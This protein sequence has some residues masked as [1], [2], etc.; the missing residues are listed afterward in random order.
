MERFQLF[1][2]KALKSYEVADHMVH[3]T[4]TVVKDPKIMLLA[5]THLQEA[6]NQAIAALLYIDYYYKRLPSFPDDTKGRM[7]I[8]RRFTCQKYNIPRE[9][10]Q[11]IEDINTINKEHK[12]SEMEFRRK[13]NF[14]IASKNYRLRTVN[15]EKLKNYLYSTK[16]LFSKLLEVK[17]LYDRRIG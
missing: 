2:K 12:S 10:I 17:R 15:S 3:M 11:V 5:I 7:D 4:Y 9:I 6:C 8:F 13:N 14:V 16:P 1:T